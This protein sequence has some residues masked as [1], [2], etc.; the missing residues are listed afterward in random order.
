MEDL[1]PGLL[2]AS[3][4]VAVLAVGRHRRNRPASVAPHAPH[5]KL[6]PLGG[7][8]MQ[9]P[10]VGQGGAPLGDLYEYLDEADAMATLRTAHAAGI[11][12]FDTSPWYGVGLSEARF[13]LGLHRV[14]RDSFILQTKVGRDLIPNRRGHEGRDVGWSGGLHFRIQFDYTSAG[15]ERQL[16]ASLQR[17]GLGHVDSLVIHDLE[18]TQHFDHAKGDD[19]VA[20]AR[21]H[22]KVLRESGFGGLQRMRAEGRI[23]A[24]GAGVNSYEDGEDA[25]VKRAWNVE[26]VQALLSAHAHNGLGLRGIDFLLCANLYSLLTHDAHEIGI[27]QRCLEAGV[28]VIVGGPY[29]SGILATGADPPGGRAPYFNYLPA[30]DEVRARCRRIAAVCAS[31]GVPHSIALCDAMRCDAMRCAAM[32]CAAMRCDAMRC[33]ARRAAHRGGATVPAHAPGGELRHP[34][35]QVRSGGALER[36]ADGGRDPA[37]AVG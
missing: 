9:V 17:T 34:W 6:R 16:D 36:R 13:G 24:F 2:C 35:R 8:E 30:S 27:F 26:Y 10:L 33:D 14:P 29:S 15:F 22:L 32:R 23:R 20:T 31:H 7:S 12:F 19:G 11:T 18:P 37:A 25:E 3:A 5:T 1:V 28:S 21:A 4:H